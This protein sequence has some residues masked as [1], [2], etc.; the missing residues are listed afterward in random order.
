MIVFPAIDLIAGKVVRLEQGRRDR[1]V[2]YSEDPV[3]VAQ[4]FA[5]QGATWVHVVDLSAT[6]GEDEEARAA[7]DAAIRNICALNC[8]QVDVGG[9]VRSIERLAALVEMGCKRV[10][11]GTALVRNPEIAQMAAQRYPDHVV[12]DIAA[13]DGLVR[14]DGWRDNT[15]ISATELISNLSCMGF[16]HLVYTDVRRDGMQTGIDVEM[17]RVAAHTAGFPVVASGGISGIDD[18]YVLSEAG[19]EV[20]EG[21]IVGRAIYE[22]TLNL[23]DALAAART[24][25]KKI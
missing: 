16:R 1:I 22:G 13:S 24:D 2:V 4:S 19:S 20:V 21:V 10:S 23:V 11:M 3:A 7:N 5:D 6:F 9:G 25:R 15:A 14:V 8:I 18:I 17:Y 12:A